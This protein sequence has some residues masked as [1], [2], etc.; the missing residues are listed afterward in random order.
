[1]FD[2]EQRRPIAERSDAGFDGH[3]WRTSA[4]RGVL[5]F[6]DTVTPHR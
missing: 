3:A 6:L 1:M 2:V 4:A 5:A